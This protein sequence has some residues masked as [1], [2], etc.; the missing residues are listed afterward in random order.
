MGLILRGRTLTLA[1][2]LALAGTAAYGAG[3]P[4]V[5]EFNFYNTDV[6]LVLKALSELTSAAIVED[7][8][9][10]G[11]V[12][13]HVAKKTP[14]GEVLDIILQPLGLTWRTVGEVYHI[15]LKPGERV[16][17]GR[18]GYVQ[19][20]F[21]LKHA[22]A[23][24]AAR[25]LRKRLRASG[26]VSV[27]P[28]MNSVSVTVPPGLLPEV[29]KIVRET[30]VDVAKKLVGIRIRVLEVLH[31]GSM[32]TGASFSFDQYNASLGVAGTF[33][34]TLN[35]RRGWGGSSA[36]YYYIG[37]TEYWQVLDEYFAFYHNAGTFKVGA[38]GIDQFVA[39]IRMVAGDTNVHT[40]SEPDVTVLEGQEA[41]VRIGE[42]I[43]IDTGSGFLRFEDAGIN[44]TVKPQVTKEG[45]ISLD[46]NAIVT[47]RSREKSG[48]FNVL[49]NREV[50]TSLSVLN[51]DTSRMGGLLYQ[52]EL[53]IEKKIPVLGDLPL[54]G[55]LFKKSSSKTGRKELVILLSPS[56]IESVPP[57][58]RRTAGISELVAWLVPGTTNVVLD[59]SEDVPQDNTGVFRYKVYRDVRP[60]TSV[61]RLAPVADAVPRVATSWVDEL[62][63]KR[64]ATYYYAVIAV[65]GAGNEQAVSNSPGLTIPRR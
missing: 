15:G 1:L 49:S 7:V 11:K 52:T 17:P 51:G 2:L 62:P 38:W 27:D 33:S 14:L 58:G 12:T 9:I 45:Y 28:A 35:S 64:G 57:H 60:I 40:V 55:F 42:K 8:P 59:W 36:G 47:Q 61:S 20:N 53:V 30:D 46:V 32:D 23:G 65:D 41:V 16:A 3:A 56:I 43:P 5:Q 6:H 18:P 21:T 50:K 4:T 26:V 31:D 54:I 25:R 63:K 29:E 39:R 13:V 19:K 34:D 24:E 22:P 48:D 44:L 37:G 10:E